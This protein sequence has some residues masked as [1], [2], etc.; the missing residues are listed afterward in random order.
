MISDFVNNYFLV[1]DRVFW[2][3][4]FL[5]SVCASVPSILKAWHKF[6]D[7]SLSVV[8]QQ[9]TEPVWKVFLFSFKS[10]SARHPIITQFVAYRFHFLK[11]SS[12]MRQ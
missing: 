9:N 4:V 11:S 8:L 10:G 5:A 7:D 1:L 2:A 3:L 12:A 6:N